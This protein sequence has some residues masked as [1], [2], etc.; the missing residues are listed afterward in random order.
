MLRNHQVVAD[1]TK[2]PTS[3]VLQ[4]NQTYS[5][6]FTKSGSFGYRDALN[7]KRRGTVTVR[8]GVSL[9]AAPATVSYGQSAT[10]SGAVSSAACRRDRD[11]R[12]N[13]VREDDVHE[14]RD[15]HERREWRLELPGQADAEHGLPVRTGRTPRAP[16]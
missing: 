16:S 10:L 8:P 5:Y 2:F 14:A 6:T 11:G 3:P 9:T 1:Q 7:T 13:G 12:R 4:A 15:C